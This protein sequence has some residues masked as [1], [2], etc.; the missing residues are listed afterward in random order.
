LHKRVPKAKININTNGFLLTIPIYEDLI[1]RGAN[2]IYISEYT[3]M[4]PKVKELFEYIR[5]KKIKN[6]KIKYR[7]FSDSTE[8]F[9]IYNRGGEIKTEKKLVRPPCIYS[10]QGFYIDY[11]GDVV[12]CCNDYHSSVTFGNLKEK[13]I[14]E[15]WNSKK[16]KKIRKELWKKNFSIL[17]ICKKCVGLE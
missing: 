7:R 2:M 16:F 9:A 14:M 3:K 1:K 4:P 6:H 13:T 10:Q 15:I 12:L 11:K 5:E 8:E 17:P